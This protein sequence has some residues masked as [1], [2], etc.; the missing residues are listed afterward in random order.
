MT[1]FLFT[2]TTNQM[3][4]HITSPHLYKKILPKQFRQFANYRLSDRS[5]Q[6]QTLQS[7][8]AE[9]SGVSAVKRAIDEAFGEEEGDIPL[10]ALSKRVLRS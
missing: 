9:K 1:S 6:K 4:A 7:K 8:M 3:T 10:L 2:S 5:H